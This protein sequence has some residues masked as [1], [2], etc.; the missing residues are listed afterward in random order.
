MSG[1]GT[2]KRN[3]LPNQLLLAHAMSSLEENTKDEGAPGSSTDEPKENPIGGRGCPCPL[4]FP[5]MYAL[6]ALQYFDERLDQTLTGNCDQEE[7][8]I[9]IWLLTGIKP[10]HPCS[11]LG[12]KTWQQL[13]R[14]LDK[15]QQRK[16]DHI[17]L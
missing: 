7:I 14:S 10:L 1:P 4:K 13:Y 17:I 16:K 11:N 8:A 6:E 5:K 9:M 12:C 15:G 2:K 3:D